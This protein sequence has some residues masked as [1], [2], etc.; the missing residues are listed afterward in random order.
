MERARRLRKGTQFDTVY[1]EG[2]ATSG[3]LVVL[4]VVPNGI[5]VTRWGFAV[6]KRLEKR[7]VKRNRMRR[8]LREAARSLPVVAG[9]DIVVTARQGASPASY[10]D[11][12]QALARQLE[13][14]GLLESGTSD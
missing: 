3:P 9:C 8:R 5:A 1:R 4:R 6:G 14:A 7:A 11:L 13:R 2:T 10:W 12:R